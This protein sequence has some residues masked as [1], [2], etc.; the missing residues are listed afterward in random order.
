MWF[1]DTQTQFSQNGIEKSWLG[2]LITWGTTGA[3]ITLRLRRLFSFIPLGICQTQLLWVLVENLEVLGLLP[4][5]LN[6]VTLPE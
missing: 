5:M 6:A 4:R 2:L 1:A 3:A